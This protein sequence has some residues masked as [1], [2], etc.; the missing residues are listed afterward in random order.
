M[1][2]P[3]PRLLAT[4]VLL[5][6]L[7]GAC[8]S[9]MDELANYVVQVKARKST[10]IDPIPQI[11]PYEAFTYVPGARRDPFVPTLP[12]SARNNTLRPDLNRNKE[13]LE[14]FPLDALKMVG[15]I[16]YN[17]VLYAMVK[18][19]DGVIHRVAAGN[20][21]GQ[22]FGRITK[23]SEK[24]VDLTEVVADGFG[25]YKEQPAVL[26]AEEK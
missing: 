15:V 25:G 7:L 4:A 9:D 2:A 14:E 10:A 5:S 16:D 11:K 8:S 18:A 23:V 17:R 12:E 21:M 13:A 24:E 26:A 1:S 19:P 22:N 3:H 20:H 6:F